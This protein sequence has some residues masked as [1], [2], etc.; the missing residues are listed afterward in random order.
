MLVD[1][2]NHPWVLEV[3]MSPGIARRNDHQNKIVQNMCTGMLRQV[4]SD[5]GEDVSRLPNA[6]EKYGRWEALILG[7]KEHTRDLFLDNRNAVAGCAIQPCTLHRI[8]ALFTRCG[9]QLVLQR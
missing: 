5:A 6:D 8:D 9:K 2:D 1:D 7:D 4:F 3:N